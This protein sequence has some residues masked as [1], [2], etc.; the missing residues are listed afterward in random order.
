MMI[1]SDFFQ[2]QAR[3]EFRQE[4]QAVNNA[5]QRTDKQVNSEE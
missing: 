4:G 3:H 5:V 2:A 1:I